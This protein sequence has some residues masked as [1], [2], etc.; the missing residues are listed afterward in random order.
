[1]F[2]CK[3][4]TAE[5]FR[6]EVIATL[7]SYE[8]SAKVDAKTTFRSVKDKRNGEARAAA[9][10]IAID[11]FKNVVIEPKQQ[12][13][14]KVIEIDLSFSVRFCKSGNPK[15]ETASNYSV[16]ST[17]IQNRTDANL[18][19]KAFRELHADL[20]WAVVQHD[21]HNGFKIVDFI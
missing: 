2:T 15:D 8:H 5:E 14:I 3:C 20:L 10:R 16:V 21:S 9:Y 12:Q 13:D 7:E 4:D 18:I 19:A 17:N 11:F 1:M 6:A